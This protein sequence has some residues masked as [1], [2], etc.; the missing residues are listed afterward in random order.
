MFASAAPT[1]KNRSGNFL[2]NLIAWV[3]TARSASS[4]TT[5]SWLWPRSTSASPYAWRVATGSVFASGGT[6]RIP[7]AV[8][9][10][11]LLVER[12]H[13]LLQRLGREL[14]RRRLA[15][16]AE[17]PLHP[18]HALALRGLGDDRRRL[19]HRAAALQ[20]LHHLLHGVAVDLDRVPSEGLELRADVADVHNLLGG[21]VGLQMVV[22]DDCG[23]VGHPEVDRGRR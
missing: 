10:L 13:Q 6:L 22:V 11:R 19:A 16:E 14:R 7:R 12:R 1:L 23:E 5:S 17:P 8:Q 4:A 15:V 3:E 21:P 20:R 18:R 2:P 9:R